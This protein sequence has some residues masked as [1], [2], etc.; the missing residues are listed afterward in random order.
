MALPELFAEFERI[1]RPKVDWVV[2]NSWRFGQVAHWR[3]G[4][5]LRNAL[6]RMMPKSAMEKQLHRV[7]D[8]EE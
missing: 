2:N 6:M 7:F 4:K 8:I 1:R 5:G 3:Y